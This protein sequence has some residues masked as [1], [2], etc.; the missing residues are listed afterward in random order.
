MKRC[1]AVML[2][3]VFLIAVLAS[4]ALA[5]ETY[6]IEFSENVPSTLSYVVEGSSLGYA[7]LDFLIPEGEY[8]YEVYCEVE[9]EVFLEGSGALYVSYEL[10]KDEE[11]LDEFY[12]SI[13]H[14]P[15]VLYPYFE[16]ALE[17]E[18]VLELC[19]DLSF[20][21]FAAFLFLIDGDVTENVLFDGCVLTLTPIADDFLSG[22]GVVSSFL[23]AS[24]DL[25]IS[26]PLTT[27]LTAAGLVGVG[28]TVYTK[29]KKTA[30]R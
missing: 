29:V 18:L 22:V 13:S 6:V 23:S 16:Y 25:M 12:C 15:I 10:M 21:S 11:H 1:F 28:V 3:V 19:A 14:L 30:R 2:T 26:N 17:F 20:N 9:G 27:T 5:V 4:P 7:V 8:T 24:F